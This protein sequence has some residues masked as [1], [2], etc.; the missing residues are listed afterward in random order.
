MSIVVTIQYHNA[1]RRAAGFDE[2][3]VR[4]PSGSS[5]HD[6]LYQLSTTSGAALRSLLFTAEGDIVSHVV[7]FRNR[8]LVARDQFDAEL[9]DGDEL[10]LFPA[11]SGG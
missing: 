9:V 6:A 3:D 1:L 4:L 5:V 11:V 2:E 10:K 7:V 8:K